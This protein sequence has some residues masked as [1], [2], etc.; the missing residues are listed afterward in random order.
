[1]LDRASLTA[2]RQRW[3]TVNA[4]ET[5]ERQS[6][7]ITER[8]QQMNALLRLAMALNILP[9]G[10]DVAVNEGRERWLALYAIEQRKGA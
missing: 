8:W 1:M 5:A 4:I 3:Q 6:T 10:D 2:Y 9:P 7:S